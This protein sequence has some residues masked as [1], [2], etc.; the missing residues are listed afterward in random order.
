M[1]TRIISF[2]L[3]AMV[4]IAS[5]QAAP[6]LKNEDE[7]IIYALGIKI[8]M[9]LSPFELSSKELTILHRGMRD[10]QKG[11]LALDPNQYQDKVSELAAKRVGVRAE[12]ERRDGAAY[13]EKM[14]K[15]PGARVSGSGLVWFL[16][17]KGNGPKPKVSSTVLAHYR[18]TLINGKEFDSSYARNE[19]TEFPLNQVIPC[20]TD[21]M[22]QMP[23]GSKA[24]LVCP[25]DIAYGN[26]GAAPAI[27]P[28]ATLIFNVELLEIR[29][30]K[31][32]PPPTKK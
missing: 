19:P 11:E 5:V 18:G 17:K 22:T 32:T 28:G 3:A 6:N 27:P 15:K 20:W 8:M 4:S 21:G 2:T 25:A 13:I 9:D 10:A 24:T 26:R 31:G 16:E 7:K 30:K 29:P 23:V 1:F 14:K 12:R